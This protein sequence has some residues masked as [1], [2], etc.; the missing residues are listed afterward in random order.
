MNLSIKKSIL[1]WL[2][3]CVGWI[4]VS[5]SG[6][7]SLE[8]GSEVVPLLELYTSQGC[9]SC[10]PA[11]RWVSDLLEDEAL[12]KGYVPV[13]FHV[14]YWDSLGWKDPY[15]RAVFT[16]RQRA[17]ASELGMRTIYTPGFFYQGEEWRGF[18]QRRNLPKVKAVSV[19]TL[20]AEISGNEVQVLFDGDPSG[21]Q[22]HVALLGFDLETAVARGENGGRHL[23]SDFVVLEYLSTDMESSGATRMQLKLDAVAPRYGIAIWLTRKSAGAAPIQAVGGFL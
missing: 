18:F 5:F 12:W 20:K 10:P 19:G 1:T 21:V 23:K 9:S 16:Q 22:V 14:D 4:L 17:Y 7:L 3:L 6:T 13:V 8:S 2:G 15:A 11:E